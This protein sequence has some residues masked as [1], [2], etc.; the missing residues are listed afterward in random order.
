MCVSKF[1]THTHIDSQKDVTDS[2]SVELRFTSVRV[3]LGV[4]LILNYKNNSLSITIRLNLFKINLQ[5][6][7]IPSD[8]CHL[9][10]AT[11]DLWKIF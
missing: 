7:L 4:P 11:I 6:L 5:N 8:S 10:D 1:E 3:G 2:K 9:L